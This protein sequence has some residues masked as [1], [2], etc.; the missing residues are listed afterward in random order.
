[1]SKITIEEFYAAVAR[2]CGDHAA[3]CDQIVM[4]QVAAAAAAIIKVRRGIP[5]HE[6]FSPTPADIAHTLAGLNRNKLRKLK[7]IA[8]GFEFVDEMSVQ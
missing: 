8:E 5:D 4:G 1:M 6:L 2:L 3:H 7:R